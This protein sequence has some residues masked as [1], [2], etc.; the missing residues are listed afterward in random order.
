VGSA[1]LA[2]TYSSAPWDAVP[3]ALGVFTAEFGMGS[4]ALPP[5]M[6]TR[7]GEPARGLAWFGRLPTRDEPRGCLLGRAGGRGWPLRAGD[8]GLAVS[9]D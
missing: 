1:G 2:A 3:L 9:S 5:A 8:M 4:G 6:A 7:P